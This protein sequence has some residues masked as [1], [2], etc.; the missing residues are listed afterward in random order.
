MFRDNDKVSAREATFFIIASLIEVGTL[1]FSR[2][3]TR[4]VGSDAWL[5]LI[6]SNLFVLPAIFIMVKLGQRFYRHGFGEYS[7][8]IAGTA[9]GWILSAALVVYW[10]FV[11]ARVLRAVSNVIM[12]TLLD[13]TPMEVIGF[14]FLLVAAYLCWYGIEPLC[15][16]SVLICIV[17]MPTIIIMCLSVINEFKIDN[18]LPFLTEGPLPVLKFGFKEIGE[19]TEMTFFLF[20]IPFIDKSGKAMK[21][22]LCALLIAFLFIFF[23]LVLTIGVMGVD[24]VKFQLLPPITLLESAEFIGIFIERLGVVFTGLWII[25]IFPTICGL[26]FAAAL[27][28]SQMFGFKSHRPFIIPLVPLIYIISA[29]PKGMVETQ[30]FFEFLIPYGIVMLLFVPLLLYIIAIVRGVK[31]T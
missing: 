1:N 6:F 4:E 5:A 3:A 30:D 7:R 17:V 16:I 2:I 9:I 23:V 21:V 29:I 8:I 13:K 15:R 20:L 11:S 25:M 26:M 10:L 31:D 14:S 27:V 24:I 19:L 12:L 18:L 28:L 22:A